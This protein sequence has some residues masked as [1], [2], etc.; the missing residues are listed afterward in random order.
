VQ[1]L[2]APRLKPSEQRR[3]DFLVAVYEF[4]DRQSVRKLVRLR[5][6]LA[7]I[8]F[9]HPRAFLEA[10]WHRLSGRGWSD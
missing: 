10:A 7:G 2:L 3:L 5:V 8:P 1:E 6:L 9:R 4:L